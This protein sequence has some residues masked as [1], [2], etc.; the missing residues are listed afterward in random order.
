MDTIKLQTLTNKIQMKKTIKTNIC[1]HPLRAAL[2]LALILVAVQLMMPLALGQRK[3]ASEQTLGRATAP[4]SWTAGPSMPTVL[5]RS[6]GV[7]FPA[8]GR[9][10]AMGG[11][12]S[13]T[14]GSDVQNPREYN[15]GTNSWTIRSETTPDNQMNNMAC[16]V[17]TD[18]GTPWIYCVGGS[19]AGATTAAARVFRFN[20]VTSTIQSLAADWPGDSDGITLPGGFAVYNNKLYVFGG[21]QINTSMKNGIWEFTPGTNTWVTKTATLPIGLGYIPTATIGSFIYTS[22]GSTWDGTTINDNSASFRYDPV[23]DSIIAIATPP[24]VMSETRSV[25]V[26]GSANVLGG[27]RTAPN[28]NN[29]VDVY[30]PGTN[31]WSLGMPFVTPRRNFPAD[32]DGCTIWLAG[33][34]AADGLTPLDS[35]EIMPC[36]APTI[37]SAVSRKTHGGAGT[38]DVSLPLTGSSGV[39]CRSGGG[40]GDYTMVVTFTGNVTV[41][42]SPQAQVTSGIGCVGTAGSCTG[43]VSVSGAVVTV[44]LTNVANAQN[45]TVQINGVNT[46]S[47]APAVNVTVPMGILIGDSNA[48]RS[49]NASDVSQ[50]KGQIGQPVTGSNFRTDINAN[51][52]INAGD[53]S[54]V[55]SNLGTGIP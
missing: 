54:Q 47:D 40:T 51:G 35:M 50:V 53:V 31:S 30:A 17:L 44:P 42:G 1:A 37:A 8:N 45:I 16:G 3:S 41:T 46:A 38:F 10:Y 19:A 14:A 48:N 18:A 25:N 20:P 2:S 21:F 23:A 13:D 22:G 7:Y 34:Y 9:F 52:S 32:T 28:P 43:T 15:P 5:V 33:G 49:V 11:R 12:T 55:K 39:E 29:E 24:R 26:G 4:D 36:S 6:V 27:G